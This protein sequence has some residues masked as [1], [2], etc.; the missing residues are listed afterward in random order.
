MPVSSESFENTVEL[1]KCVAHNSSIKS[2]RHLCSFSHP[3]LSRLHA[4]SCHVMSQVKDK[5][6]FEDLAQHLRT[7]DSKIATYQGKPIT[8]SAGACTADTVWPGAP[9]LSLSAVVVSFLCLSFEN[10]CM[11]DIVGSVGVPYL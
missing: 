10:V 11:V 8:T 5:K 3:P 1:K 6:A 2:I 4:M 9:C 7:G